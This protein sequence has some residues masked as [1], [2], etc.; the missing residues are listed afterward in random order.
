VSCKGQLLPINLP[1]IGESIFRSLNLRG[2][3]TA[4]ML[5]DV[6]QPG[7]Q[8]LDLTDP[9]YLWLQRTKRYMGNATGPQVAAQN[10]QV[11]FRN[12]AGSGLIMRVE[13]LLLTTNANT[14]V[15]IFLS[16]VVNLGLVQS[17]RAQALDSRQEELGGLSTPTPQGLLFQGTSAFPIP[18]NAYFFTATAG[19]IYDIPFVPIVLKQGTYLRL[20]AG[21]TNTS[22]DVRLSWRERIPVPSELA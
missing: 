9:E 6:V 7:V 18:P 4:S 10:A 19:V 5:T 11:E 20:V 21:T 17:V 15:G 3:L 22:L 12:N 8:T 1:G 16:T 14:G 13:H 2:G